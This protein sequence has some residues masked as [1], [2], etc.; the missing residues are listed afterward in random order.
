MRVVVFK[1]HLGMHSAA[2]AA[3]VAAAAAAAAAAALLVVVS[4]GLGVRK[5]SA[6]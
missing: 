2:A 5:G 1:R 3:A 4:V 6:V